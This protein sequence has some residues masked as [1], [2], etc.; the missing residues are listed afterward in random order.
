[1]PNR[2]GKKDIRVV[3]SEEDITLLK[4]LSGITERSMS[5]LLQEAVT[6]FLSKETIQELIERYNLDTPINEES[7]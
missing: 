7:E 5:S 2:P 6:D 4:R 1:M 3:L